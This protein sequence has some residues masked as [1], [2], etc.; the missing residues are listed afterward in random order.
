MEQEVPGR[1]LE[2]ILLASSLKTETLKNLTELI[3][4]LE[5]TTRNRKLNQITLTITVTITTRISSTR[6]AI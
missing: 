3:Q 4:N 1:G 5:K 6:H 2:P